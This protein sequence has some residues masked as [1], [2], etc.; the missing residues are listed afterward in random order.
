MSVLV[1]TYK[2]IEAKVDAY[3]WGKNRRGMKDI[4]TINLA[5]EGATK[6]ENDGFGCNRMVANS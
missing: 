6:V 5:C 2:R 4:K 3:L 1:I